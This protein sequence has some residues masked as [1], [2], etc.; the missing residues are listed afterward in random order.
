MQQP[1]IAT[2]LAY[3]FNLS[4]DSLAEGKDTIGFAIRPPQLCADEVMGFALAREDGRK[5][6]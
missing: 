4:G 3:S 5:R 1:V 6:P 2:L